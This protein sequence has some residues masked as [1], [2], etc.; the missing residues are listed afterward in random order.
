M[1]W[2]RAVIDVFTV[3]QLP[4]LIASGAR[5]RAYGSLEGQ[6]AAV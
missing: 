6:D 5:R 2:G 3:V 1:D 4:I